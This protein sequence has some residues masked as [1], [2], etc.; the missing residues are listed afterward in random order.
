MGKE[1]I[2]RLLESEKFELVL[3][4]TLDAIISLHNEIGG[5]ALRIESKPDVLP[6][7]QGDLP[8]NEEYEKILACVRDYV[9]LIAPD[10]P[11]NRVCPGDLSRAHMLENDPKVRFSLEQYADACF[12]G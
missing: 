3:P 12:F 7:I 10:L 4:R 8:T 2:P 11:L 1:D 9:S 5:Q 6:R